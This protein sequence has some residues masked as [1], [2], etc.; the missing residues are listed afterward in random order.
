MRSYG[1]HVNTRRELDHAS[2]SRLVTMLTLVRQLGVGEDR[3]TAYWG[4]SSLY[5]AA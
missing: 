4:A 3:K 2:L 1:T 5:I